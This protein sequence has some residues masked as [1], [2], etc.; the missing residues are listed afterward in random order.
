MSEVHE[1]GCLCGAV[2]WRA[3]SSPK[4]VNHC[5]CEMCRRAGGS[6]FATWA[7]F[8]MTDFSY[9]KGTPT[10]RQSSAIARRAF[11]VSCGSALHWQ[12]VQHRD[13]IDVTV[14]TA[15]QP[16]R[17]LPKEHLWT[18]GQISWLHINDG[19]PRHR[20]DRGT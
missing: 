9:T 5:H 1:G 17:L 8:A 2:R 16:D 14:G 19:L 18:E 12:H 4:N 7:T 6:A 3:T 11:C 13:S 20:L 15:D 10:W